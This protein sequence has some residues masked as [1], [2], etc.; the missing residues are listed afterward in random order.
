MIDIETWDTAPSAVI[1]AIAIVG[2]DLKDGTYTLDATRSS[3]T[4]CR[5]TVDEQIQAGRTV[6]TE[7]VAWWASQE[8]SL[9]NMLDSSREVAHIEVFKPY[10]LAEVE[11]HLRDE[12]HGLVTDP[13]AC[14]WSRGHFDIAILE[15]LLLAAGCPVPWSP[16]QVRDVR[17]LD[18]IT[19]P[20]ESQM[21]HHPLADCL[22]EIQQVCAALGTA[23]RGVSS[24]AS[25]HVQDDPQLR[26]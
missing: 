24:R 11:T 23:H 1:R 26:G 12:L 16:K 6:S 17:T 13:G 3:V 15:H 20:I 14:I 22:A 18:E 7:T 19:P 10:R 9:G 25:L 8:K 4:D 21:P 5:R 2:F